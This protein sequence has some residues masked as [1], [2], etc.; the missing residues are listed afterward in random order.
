M[1]GQLTGGQIIPLGML[2][3]CRRAAL[4]MPYLCQGIRRTGECGE[5]NLVLVL[6]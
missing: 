4:Q 5:K 6:K 2:K 3:R 1:L